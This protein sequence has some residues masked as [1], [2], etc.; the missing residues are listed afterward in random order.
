MGVSIMA[1]IQI[2]AERC[3]KC[4]KCVQVCPTLFEQ[5]AKGT[6]PRLLD[7]TRCNECG[8]CVAMCPGEAIAHSSFPTGS[9]SPIHSERLPDTTQL[10][11]LLRSRRSIREF[12]PKPVE[13]ALIEQII[14]GARCA[15]SAHNVQSTQYIVVQDPTVLKQIVEL[16]MAQYQWWRNLLNNPLVR[17]ITR[18]TMGA[19]RQAMLNGLSENFTAL[20]DRH[21]QGDDPI[22]RDA[23][24]LLIFH[25]DR[26]ADFAGVNANLALQNASLVCETLKLG[27]FYTGY[28]V[29]GSHYNARLAK[30][31]KLPRDHKIYAGLAIGYPRFHYQNWIERKPA[32]IQ[33]FAQGGKHP[34]Q[35]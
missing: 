12:R 3:R 34:N 11:E 32:Q 5:D 27:A 7:T 14:A 23:P 20:I 1:T 26:H 15:P 31:L 25:A 16:T 29:A 30:L 22:L 35:R 17:A 33:W 6:I 18:L 10:L 9:I 8:H 4:G 24:T 28:V 19:T 21:Q 2:D 13:R